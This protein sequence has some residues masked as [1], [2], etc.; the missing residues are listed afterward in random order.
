MKRTKKMDWAKHAAV[1]SITVLVFFTGI[2]LGTLLNKNKL[3]NVKEISEELRLSTMSSEVEFA[4]LAENPCAIEDLGFLSD[5]LHELSMKVEYM[6]NQL[7]SKNKDVQ[8]LKNFYSIIQLRHWVLMTKIKE[9]CE[10]EV[11][12]IVYLYSN[13]GDCKECA[14][15]GFILSYLKRTEK[16][17][18]YSVDINI[19]NNAVRTLKQVYNV[20]TA[21]TLIINQ[22]KHEE[23]KTLNQLKEL[24]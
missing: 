4:I 1:L 5:D 22:E 14:D 17:N 21:P 18:I 19:N 24:I 12:N 2:L 10:T 15:Q 3:D 7:G 16:V 6:E 20:K 9:Q 13:E 11:T 23:F 8:E